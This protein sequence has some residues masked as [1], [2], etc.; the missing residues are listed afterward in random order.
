VNLGSFSLVVSVGI[1]MALCFVPSTARATEVDLV[2]TVTLDATPHPT[3]VESFSFDTTAVSA[4]LSNGGA[5]GRFSL[6]VTPIQYFLKS[7]PS[8]IAIDRLSG[9]LSQEV[10]GSPFATGICRAAGKRL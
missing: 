8:T 2:C 7:D 6:Q 4:T 5:T 10:A 9:S 3:W 1:Q